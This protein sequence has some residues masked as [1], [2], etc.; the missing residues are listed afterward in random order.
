M[1]FP[2]VRRLSISDIKDIP[3][4]RETTDIVFRTGGTPS[5][6]SSDACD[7]EIRGTPP[8]QVFRDEALEIMELL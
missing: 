5:G 2:D 7:T 8:A 4:N 3:V 1:L 6:T